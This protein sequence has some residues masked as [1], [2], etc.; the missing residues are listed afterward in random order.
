MSSWFG[1]P[2]ARELLRRL[3]D[4]ERGSIA[5]IFG[6]AAT[7]LLVGIGVSVDLA[8]AYTAKSR[9][10]AAVDATVLAVAAN[11]PNAT[12][13]TGQMQTVANAFMAANYP[14]A[15]GVTVG[16][17]TVTLSGQS[18]TVTDSATYTTIFLGIAS[19]P[20]IT[21]NAT[22]TALRTVSGL[23]VVLLLDNTASI[24]NANFATIQS[25]ASQLATNLFGSTTSNNTTVRIA[26]VP[27]TGAINAG[28][29]AHNMVYGSA[30]NLTGCVVERY[31]TFGTVTSSYT[32]TS[33]SG[34]S[35]VYNLVAADLDTAVTSATNTLQ[36]W[37][38]SAG[39]PAA[40]RPLTNTLANI[41]TT[42]SAMTNAG[43]SGTMGQV[44]MAWAYRVLSPNGPFGNAYCWPTSPT[45]CTN[46]APNVNWKK[47]VV[48]MTDGIPEMTSAY[49]GFGNTNGSTS[50]GCATPT[51]KANNNATTGC[52]SA[53]NQLINASSSLKLGDMQEAAVC[54]ALRANGVTIFSVYFYDGTA[55]PTSYVPAVSYCAGTAVGDG[56]SS[57]YYYYENATS[58]AARFATI[59]DQ[60]TN[61][62]LTQ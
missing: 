38:G 49:N 40:I 32:A 3:R 10:Q 44:G 21:L 27:F 41:T 7:A 52:L 43:G 14:S 12:T 56:T 24:T 59:G 9:L 37:R 50:G 8:Q 33:T 60:L 31:S 11:S 61:L 6:A 54:D 5:V 17:P 19:V 16:T 1:G 29:Y 23:E 48:L 34:T 15:N 35:L 51:Y 2:A 62:R 18:V 39:C 45:S 25:A 26:V 22:S 53:D 20:T 58:L 42:I 4:C 55:L 28:S 13:V 30:A 46:Q 57:G 36:Q 47:V